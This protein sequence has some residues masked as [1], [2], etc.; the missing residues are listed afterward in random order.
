[1]TETEEYVFPSIEERAKRQRLT[2]FAAKDTMPEI[3]RRIRNLIAADREMVMMHRYLHR[4]G[5]RP[6]TPDLYVGLRVDHDARIPVEDWDH[7]ATGKGWLGSGITVLLKPELR[8]F[9]VSFHEKT[10]GTPIVTEDD[11]RKAF[12]RGQDVERKNL[13]MVEFEG[14]T[15]ESGESSKDSIRIEFWNEHGVGQ[16]VVVKF[17]ASPWSGD[18]AMDQADVL[19]LLAERSETPAN[20]EALRHLAGRLRYEQKP[21]PGDWDTEGPTATRKEVGR[22]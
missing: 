7:D 4:H 5:D 1:M 16:E 2:V 9:G 3:K 13:T 12:G 10:W 17:I 20:P 15:T 18:V 21:L 14:G 19:D 8:A 22:R 11:V 6:V